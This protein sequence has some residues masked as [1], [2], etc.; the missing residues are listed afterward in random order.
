MAAASR[1]SV[2]VF[3]LLAFVDLADHSKN[4]RSDESRSYVR[5]VEYSDM[6]RRRQEWVSRAVGNPDLV[7]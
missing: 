3:F 5:A 6:F 2:S 4:L 1:K 7:A